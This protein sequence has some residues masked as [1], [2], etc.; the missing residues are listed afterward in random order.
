MTLYPTPV[1]L[2]SA[3]AHPPNCLSSAKFP[4]F[5][6]QPVSISGSATAVTPLLNTESRSTFRVKTTPGRK[7]TTPWLIPMSKACICL[8]MAPKSVALLIRFTWVSLCLLLNRMAIRLSCLWCSRRKLWMRCLLTKT[9]LNPK[10]MWIMQPLIPLLKRKVMP[11]GTKR[12]VC[13]MRM[14]FPMNL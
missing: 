4:N 14:L 9:P 10:R 7:L 6:M 8:R 1:Q 13:R 11:F 2:L 5:V 12:Q 3:K